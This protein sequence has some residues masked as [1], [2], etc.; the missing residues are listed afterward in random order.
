M[1]STNVPTNQTHILWNKPRQ[2]S[3]HNVDKV[4][5]SDKHTAMERKLA[6]LEV[7]LVGGG[8]IFQTLSIYV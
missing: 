8:L 6:F 1:L 5:Q 3:Q 2:C 7:Y 4:N